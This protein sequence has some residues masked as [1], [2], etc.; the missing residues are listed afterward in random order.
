ME[1]K[2]REAAMS[3]KPGAGLGN[4]SPAAEFRLAAGG[5][6]ALVDDTSSNDWGQPSRVSGWDARDV[7]RHLVEWF[8]PFLSAGAGVE[9]PAGP[10]ID[11]DPAA[12]WHHLLN[13]VQALLDD[14]ATEHRTLTNPHIGQMPLP[15]AI[16]RFFTG[17][18]FLH[19]WDLA[20]ATGQDDTLDPAR[21]A[22]MLEGMEPMDQ[23][24]GD[25]GQVRP[26]GR[27]SRRRRRADTANWLHR[28]K[29]NVGQP[30]TFKDL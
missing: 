4:V 20:R 10:S 18:V 9:R 24:L 29:P 16:S 8:P 5:F 17:D 15:L 25:S 1:I 14:P 19:S 6:S 2:S 26:Q 13:A 27:G 7:V 11:D 28:P 30:V 3:L 23:V 21:C 22:A 12:A